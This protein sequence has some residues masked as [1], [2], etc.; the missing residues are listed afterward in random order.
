MV[1]VAFIEQKNL[2][3]LALTQSTKMS[4]AMFSFSIAL[5]DHV[6]IHMIF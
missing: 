3:T 5:P 1:F 2:I 6:C 4:D